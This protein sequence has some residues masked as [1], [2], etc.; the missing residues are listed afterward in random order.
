MFMS[1]WSQMVSNECSKCEKL[2]KDFRV[3]C[4]LRKTNFPHLLMRILFAI[5]C[6]SCF[7]RD[8]LLF[9]VLEIAFLQAQLDMRDDFRVKIGG[10]ENF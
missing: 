2:T 8:F 1:N 4:Q 9:S 5:F 10:S 6:S 3:A 7:S